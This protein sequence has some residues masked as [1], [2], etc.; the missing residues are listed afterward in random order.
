MIESFRLSFMGEGTVTLMQVLVGTVL[1]IVILFLGLITFN[2]VEQT[3]VD[4]A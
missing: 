2:R 1:S 4:T 3:S